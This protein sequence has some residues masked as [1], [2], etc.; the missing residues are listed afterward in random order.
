[1]PKTAVNP[2]N[3][4]CASIRGLKKREDVRAVIEAVR[5]A[6]RMMDHTQA[7]KFGYGDKV[8]FDSK[9]GMRVNGIVIGVLPRNI[10][11][12]ADGGTVWKVSPSLLRSAS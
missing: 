2:I 4:L 11:V 8:C 10:K 9:Y 3:Q 6:Q 7:M 12:R 5:H 1:M